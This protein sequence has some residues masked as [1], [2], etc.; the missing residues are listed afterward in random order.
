MRVKSVITRPLA[1][2][3]VP[4][5]TGKVRIQGFAWAGTSGVRLVEVSAD[6]GKTWRPAGFMGENAP[7]AWRAW[8]TEVEVKK[9]TSLTVMARATD[10][11]GVTQPLEA[12][13]NLGGY[14]NNSI[15][16]VTFRVR[17]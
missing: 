9:P 6:G 2:S 5:G 17:A 4:L 16:K 15:H 14:A 10:G 13:P 12:K 1:G 7:M 8:A 3:R 11:A